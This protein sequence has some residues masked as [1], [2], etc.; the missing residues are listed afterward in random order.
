MQARQK[1]GRANS[2]G[3]AVDIDTPVTEKNIRH[4]R[5]ADPDADQWDDDL[6][7]GCQGLPQRIGREARND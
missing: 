4:E 3:K 1:S 6:N 7:F 5:I 2:S